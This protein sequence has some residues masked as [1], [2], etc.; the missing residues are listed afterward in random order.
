[1][2]FFANVKRTTEPPSPQPQITP[3]E[4]L[5]RIE[6]QAMHQLRITNPIASTMAQRVMFDPG[7]DLSP[8]DSGLWLI[9]LSRTESDRELYARLFYIRAAGTKLIPNQQWGF[10][11]APIIDATG[12]NGWPSME[13]Y[14]QE[15][16]C[17]DLY[18]EQILPMLKGLSAEADLSNRQQGLWS[19]S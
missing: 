10:I 13:F 12:K 14:K 3:R 9:L 5:R 7:A 1:M 16:R 8:E 11:F 19:V 15:V 2:T 4:L 6:A 18:R 17:L